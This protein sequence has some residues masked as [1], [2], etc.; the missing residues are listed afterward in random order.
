VCQGLTR[1]AASAASISWLLRM[2]I[3]TVAE[4]GVLARSEALFAD[5][6]CQ[7]LRHCPKWEDPEERRRREV[8]QRVDAVFS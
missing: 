5:T 2:H 6:A 7:E 4:K 8:E 1:E 3:E